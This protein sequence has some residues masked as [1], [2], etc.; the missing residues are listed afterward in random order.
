MWRRRG[1]GTGKLGWNPH[2]GKDPEKA[3]LDLQRG[4]ASAAHSPFLLGINNLF[5]KSGSANI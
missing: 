2:G 4:F 3:N 1:E 5:G